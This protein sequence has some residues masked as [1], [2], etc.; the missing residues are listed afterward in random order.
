M[1]YLEA[2]KLADH[3]DGSLIELGFGK[4]N[5]LTEFISYM[6]SRDVV[7]RDI[8]LYDSFE[9]YPSPVEE[10]ENAFVKGGFKRPIQP[11][12]DIRNTINKDVKLIKGFI[13]DTLEDSFNSN[14]EIAIIHSDL[15]SYSSTLYS[16]TALNSKLSID[17][18]VIVSGY[19]KYPGVKLAVDSFISSN[20]KS[21]RVEHTGDLA[22]LVK[23]QYIKLNKKVTK[24]RH[25]ISW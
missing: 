24:D 3:V 5:T 23:V 15:V 2:I 11:A 12:M 21:Y 25:K 1:E 20:K 8:Q 18:V 10:D 9:G 7:K 13:E 14:S 16:L 4:G 6:N 19:S 22:V 17:G